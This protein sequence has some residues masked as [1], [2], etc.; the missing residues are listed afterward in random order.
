MRVSVGDQIAGAVLKCY[1]RLPKK[2]KCGSDEWTVLAAFV[3]VVEEV[4]VVLS[5]ATGTKCLPKEQ[6]ASHVLSDSHAE[7]LA[8]RALCVRIVEGKERRICGVALWQDDGTWNSNV[9]LF[10]Y[11][12]KEPCGSS[13]VTIDEEQQNKRVKLD[14][15]CTVR[16]PGRGEA[17]HCVSCCDKISK[18]TALG[19]LSKRSP[20]SPPLSGIVVGGSF[21]SKDMFVQLL[22]VRQCPDM[23]IEITALSFEHDERE[24]AHPSGLAMNWIDGEKDVEVTQPNG[25][26]MGATSS[27]EIVNAKHV[28]RLAPINRV[29]KNLNEYEKRKTEWKLKVGF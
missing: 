24:G 23:L 4:P 14:V 28:S 21:E 7:V 9:K 8:R 16:K 18:W 2:G 5:L 22:R 19:L 20:V 25:K 10:L 1:R 15:G 12:S 17:T 27:N 3:A 29:V 13:R 6:E 26:K 11:T